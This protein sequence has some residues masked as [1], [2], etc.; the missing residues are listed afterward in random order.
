MSVEH[1]AEVYLDNRVDDHEHKYLTLHCFQESC[2]ALVDAAGLVLAECLGVHAHRPELTPL[3]ECLVAPDHE[4]GVVAD[5]EHAVGGEEELSRRGT[6]LEK[7]DDECDRCEYFEGNS[8]WLDL[9]KPS[10]E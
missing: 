4:D 9:K 5:T 1:I 7:H 8:H 2:G 6:V 3:L 10:N